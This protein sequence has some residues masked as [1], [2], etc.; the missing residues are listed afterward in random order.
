LSIYIKKKIQLNAIR[1]INLGTCNWAKPC[2]LSFFLFE[3]VKSDSLVLLNLWFC[4]FFEFCIIFNARFLRLCGSSFE[5]FWVFF[6]F[7]PLSQYL[8]FS[9]DSPKSSS[10]REMVFFFPLNFYFLNKYLIILINLL[11]ALWFKCSF[12]AFSVRLH[13]CL[14]ISLDLFSFL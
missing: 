11:F 12:F 13:S 10:H 9:L 4:L 8:T 7:E 14:V 6:S 3:R 1:Y 5:G 2:S